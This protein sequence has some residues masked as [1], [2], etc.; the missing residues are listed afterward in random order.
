M[1]FTLPEKQAV[2]DHLSDPKVYESYLKLRR[3]AWHF[4]LSAQEKRKRNKSFSKAVAEV[5]KRKT[6]RL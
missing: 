5:K 3:E 2:S 4:S 1:Y 6:Y